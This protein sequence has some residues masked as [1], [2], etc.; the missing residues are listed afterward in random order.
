MRNL[1]QLAIQDRI[2]DLFLLL[3]SDFSYHEHRLAWNHHH[4]SGDDDLLVPGQPALHD[5]QIALA[6]TGCNRPQFREHRLRS[7]L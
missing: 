2:P 4:V 6:L 1:S 5:N 3:T 7:G